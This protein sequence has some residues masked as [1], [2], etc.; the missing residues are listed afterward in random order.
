M[1]NPHSHHILHAETQRIPQLLLE[2]NVHASEPT[3][4]LLQKVEQL[5]SL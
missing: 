3:P 5:N 2:Q 4:F 1:S